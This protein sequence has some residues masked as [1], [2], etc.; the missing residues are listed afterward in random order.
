M[1]LPLRQRHRRMFAVIGVLLPVC[2][3]LGLVARKPAP[4][5]DSL[6]PALAGTSEPFTTL[7]WKR[8]D[9]FMRASVEASLFSG[10]IH[11]GTFAITL[12]RTANFI[13]PDLIVYWVAGNPAIKDT[14]PANAVLLGAFNSAALPLPPAAVKGGVLVLFSLADQEVVDVSRQFKL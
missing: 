4:Q 13:K 14:I 12:T 8:T 11:A 5:V 1:I 9:L 2:F 6:P 7:C 3:A 10:S